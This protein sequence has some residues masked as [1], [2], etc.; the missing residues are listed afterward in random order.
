M[1]SVGV[2]LGLLR[3]G[4]HRGTTIF[5]CAVLLLG[6]CR[7]GVP[8]IVVSGNLWSVSSIG[9]DLSSD[10]LEAWAYYKGFVL[11]HLPFYSSGQAAAVS[12]SSRDFVTYGGVPSGMF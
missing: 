1:W 7:L 12:P 6:G 3:R 11:P 10:V 5:S 8:V 4:D 2:G 9:C